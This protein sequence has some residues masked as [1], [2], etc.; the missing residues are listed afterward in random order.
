MNPNQE[1]SVNLKVT[2]I[3]YQQE[4]SINLETVYQENI[5][6]HIIM[7]DWRHKIMV[8][9]FVT[10]VAL[11]ILSKFFYQNESFKIFLFFPSLLASI[12]SAMFGIMDNNNHIVIEC[13]K[14]V[15]FKL[16]N[17]FAIG[18]GLYSELQKSY[19]PRFSYT[20]TLKYFYIFSFV[21]F[22]L[23]SILLFVK[24][25]CWNIYKVIL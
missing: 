8:R 11:L 19:K 18:S 25:S 1:L 4:Q 5:K 12:V 14:K 15:G 7:I 16:E 21:F 2:Q 20:K 22:L 17:E 23:L 6:G 13:C 10:I 24:Y 3:D 9:Y